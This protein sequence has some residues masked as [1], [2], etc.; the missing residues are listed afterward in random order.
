MFLE[1]GAEGFGSPDAQTFLYNR[2]RCFNLLLFVIK[3]EQGFGMSE[4]KAAIIDKR[5]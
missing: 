5:L 1:I 2:R 4:G 3:R